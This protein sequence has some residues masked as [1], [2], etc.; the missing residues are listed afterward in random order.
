MLRDKKLTMILPPFKFVETNSLSNGMLS[1]P[2][3]LSST[4]TLCSPPCREKPKVFYLVFFIHAVFSADIRLNLL[5]YHNY[6][7]SLYISN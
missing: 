7:F 3:S 5:L 4:L 1:S 6:I 2:S